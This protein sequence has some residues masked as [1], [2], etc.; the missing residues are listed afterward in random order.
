MRRPRTIAIRRF[1]PAG[2]QDR[3]NEMSAVWCVRSRDLSLFHGRDLRSCCQ[4]D[5]RR[6]S[7]DRG[8][9]RH[10]FAGAAAAC[11]IGE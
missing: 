2:R 5:R 11:W 4:A 3:Q 7:K 8:G 6:I 9:S 10:C 1:G